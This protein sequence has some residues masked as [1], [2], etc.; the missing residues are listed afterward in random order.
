[1]LALEVDELLLL[2]GER[3]ALRL[4]RGHQLAEELGADV[5][6]SLREEGGERAAAGHTPGVLHDLAVGGAEGLALRLRDPGLRL[7]DLPGVVEDGLVR[8]LLRNDLVAEADLGVGGRDVHDARDEG[9]GEHGERH[10]ERNLGLHEQLLIAS[11]VSS[12]I[13][14]RPTRQS[15]RKSDKCQ[16]KTLKSLLR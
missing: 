1:M 10:D 6:L 4:D 14:Q 11:E 7:Q 5:D 3:R 9:E 2:A 16:S 12:E 15:D 8:L 13:G